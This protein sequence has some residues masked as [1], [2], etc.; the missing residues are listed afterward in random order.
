MSRTS[1]RRAVRPGSVLLVLAMALS[2]A[3][4]AGDETGQSDR[5][6]TADSRQGP[7]KAKSRKE[8][9]KADSKPG[10]G[11]ADPAARPAGPDRDC[12]SFSNQ[13]EA[14]RALAGGDPHGLDGDGDGVACSSLPCPCSKA[15]AGEGQ[16]GSPGTAPA[17]PGRGESGSLRSF[18]ARVVSVTDGDTIEVEA[19]GIPDETIRLI[20]ID[21]P[22]VY[23]GVECG[24][25]AASDAMK[26]LATGLVT[27]RTDPSQDLRD[28]YG[29]LLAYVDKGGRDLGRT[30]VARGLAPAYV[31]DRVFRRYPAYRK[32]EARAR[33]T[34]RGSWKSCDIGD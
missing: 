16:G 26:R 15:A 32:A 5:K 17:G 3:A 13:A 30:M 9:Q 1:V 12:G 34:R 25:R 24:G 27:V 7:E 23:G 14:Q 4:C 22:E 19:A 2:L 21:T 6:P 33:A 10:T 8:K 18:R 20:G 28:R 11:S 31:Y 29:R